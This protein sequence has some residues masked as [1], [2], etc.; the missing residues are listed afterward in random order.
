MSLSFA[1]T[2]NVGP[3]FGPGLTR[4]VQNVL[5]RSS[6]DFSF[7]AGGDRATTLREG[8]FLIMGHLETR[9]NGVQGAVYSEIMINNVNVRATRARTL[10]FGA[11]S[12][13]LAALC[14]YVAYLKVGDTVANTVGNTSGS[15]IGLNQEAGGS[16]TLRIMR[17]SRVQ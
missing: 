12:Q 4:I 11:G 13:Q 17:L 3:N 1:S 15:T 16:L 6:P 2:N 5:Q 7:T 10:F 14:N 9:V 8:W